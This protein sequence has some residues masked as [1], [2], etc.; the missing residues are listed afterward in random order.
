[1]NYLQPIRFLI[2][3]IV[4]LAFLLSSNPVFGGN[5]Y[6]SPDD[7]GARLLYGKE[8][9]EV[10]ADGTA[11]YTFKRRIII[12]TENGRRYGA[13]NF[14]ET[15]FKKALEVTG[16]VYD[17]SGKLIFKRNKGDLEKYCGFSEYQLY[18]DI[19]DYYMNLSAGNYPFTVEYEV[20]QSIN[21][22]FAWPGWYPQWYI[23]VDTSIYELTTPAEFKYRT[24]ITGDIGEPAISEVK[25]KK[26]QTWALYDLPAF[27][28]K[29]FM[30]P[31]VLYAPGLEFVVDE[32]S[33]G[34]YDINCTDW[35]AASRS[36]NDLMKGAFKLS[37]AQRSVL[38]SIVPTQPATP[39]EC[40]RLHDFLSKRSRYVAITIGTGGWQPHSSDVTFANG[41]GDCKDLS[42]MYVSMLRQVGITAKLALVM[43]K[44]DGR[45]D[46]AFPWLNFNHVI[47]YYL[48]GT[49]TMWVDP[50]CFNCRLGDLPWT[51]EGAFALTVDSVRGTIVQ[52]PASSPEDNI[53]NRKASISLNSDLS[54]NV[55]IDL[56]AVGNPGSDLRG[57][58]GTLP[59]LEFAE[60]LKRYQGIIS[61]ALQ[62]KEC[63]VE[64]AKTDLSEIHITLR[65][66]I[67]RFARQ[68]SGKVYLDLSILPTQ[69][70]VELVDLN[71]R[72]YPVEFRYP[73]TLIDTILVQLQANYQIGQIPKDT[74]VSDQFGLF[75]ISSQSN[76]AQTTVTRQKTLSMLQVD[77]TMFDQFNEH[78]TELRRLAGQS[79][80]A[81]KR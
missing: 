7:S 21:S 26:T 68:V 38:D 2:A 14:A 36:I 4:T 25:G 40:D 10:K 35:N 18:S 64:I 56:Y 6:L 27:K 52:I 16:R 80:V 78:R 66:S 1:L 30:P 77:T 72:Q 28:T 74:S 15:L 59:A 24:K 39:S 76:G 9:V 13:I 75:R 20:T 5:E 58:A 37:K 3:A 62:I 51:V 65:G 79:L 33:Y 46:P 60:R 42:T 17:N 67:Q 61:E 63:D 49:D 11:T 31:S 12:L 47:L 71:Q 53:I 54:V 19:C 45:T 44:D 32:F 50:T 34:K 57:L 70:Q 55:V 22:L 81:E 41:Y 48:Q 29:P 8:S 43:T 69:S 73:Y 23:P